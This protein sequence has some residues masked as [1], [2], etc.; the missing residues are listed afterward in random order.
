MLAGGYRSEEVRKAEQQRSEAQ[1]A[2]DML[3]NGYRKEDIAQA[4]AQMQQART[5]A[6]WAHQ[7]FLR[8]KK[9]TEQGA[10]SLRD[11]DELYTRWQSAERAY[12]ASSQAYEKVKAGPR[13]EELQAAKARLNAA[14]EHEKLML[15]GTRTEEVQ[16]ARHEYLQAEAA[17]KLLRQGT[18][19]EQIKRAEAELSMSKGQLQ[20]I[21]AQ[22]QERNI[23]APVDAEISVMDLHPGE[24]FAPN[25][26]LATLTR[27]D[28]IWTRVY[29]PEKQLARARVGQELKIKVDAYPGKVFRGKIVQIPGVAEFTPRNVQTPEERSAQVF[30]IKITLENPDHLLRGGMNAEVELP[31]PSAPWQRVA[32]LSR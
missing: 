26:T 15:N 13:S 1:A 3:D 14:K 6:D 23:V 20:E 16:M 18:R 4:K 21:D 5:Q 19:F 28:D 11:A 2:F 8:F 25:R 32:R 17:A 30:G 24:V 29:L 27:L 7:D 12:D 22:L 10:V 9:L 31:A